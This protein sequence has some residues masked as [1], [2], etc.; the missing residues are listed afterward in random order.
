MGEGLMSNNK[1]FIYCLTIMFCWI[2]Q[3]L[4]PW[5][6]WYQQPQNMVQ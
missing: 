3:I 1:V 4:S 6:D 2:E 5:L